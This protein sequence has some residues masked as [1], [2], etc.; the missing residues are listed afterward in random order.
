MA[1]IQ[2]LQQKINKAYPDKE[3]AVKNELFGKLFQ[4]AQVNPLAG[5]LPAIVQIPIF[6]S[7]Y[8]ALTNLIAED[9]LNSG[10]L[11]VP[12]LEGPVSGSGG[13]D[14]LFS[15]FSGNP[16]WGYLG[17]LQFLSLSVLLYVVQSAAIKLNQPPRADPDAPLTDQEQQG[18][19][20]GTIIP[21]FIT[22]FSLN[23]PAG[24]SVYWI[25][26]SFFTTIVTLALKAKFK[27]VEMPDEVNRIEAMI[28][29]RLGSMKGAV[30]IKAAYSSEAGG[31]PVAAPP[32]DKMEYSFD[33]PVEAEVA[34]TTKK[35]KKR[36]AKKNKRR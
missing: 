27:N 3:A 9:K 15:I 31:A 20:V 4:T 25:A 1:K 29:R 7:L 10:F 30:K 24:L 6:V 17:T 21:L 23:A 12:S 34:L 22:F 8:R 32:V 35:K 36:K 33:A 16:T 5:C 11:F 13:L 2:P 19:L 18:Q 28:D 14:W 26:N